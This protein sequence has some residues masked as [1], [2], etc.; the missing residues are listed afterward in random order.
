MGQQ[1]HSRSI[2]NRNA[3]L[4]SPQDIYKKIHSS[5]VHY[6][7]NWSLQNA[8]QQI[9][10]CGILHNEVGIAVRMTDL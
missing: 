1:F 3:Y 4:G 8:H 7:Q 2:S 10:N 6:G 9:D 5:T